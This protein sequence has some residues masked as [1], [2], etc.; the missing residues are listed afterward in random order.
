MAYRDST[1]AT[2]NSTTPS[3]AVPAGAAIDDI[4]ILK[5][6]FDNSTGTVGFPAGFTSFATLRC[7]A[8]GHTTA[9]AWKRLTAA[10]SGTYD[11][12]LTGIAASNWV[13]QASLYSGRHT[14]D[15]PVAATTT[16]NTAAAS[17]VS[18][19]LTGV[20]AV[21]GDDIEWLSGPD[22]T[23]LN[24]GNGHTEPGSYTKDEDTENGWANMCCAH[25]N[26]VG[27]GATGTITGSFALSANTAGFNGFVIRVPAAAGG[28]GGAVLRKNSLMRL[29]VGR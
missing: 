23:A 12:T 8:D 18:I 7:T 13:C 20:T 1:T 11:I 22:V 21:A 25:R 5:V 4:A 19:A 29:G 15:P 16:Q 27:A 26:N 14:T 10:D 9:C 6:N 2:G 28:G 24:V 3:V 17:P